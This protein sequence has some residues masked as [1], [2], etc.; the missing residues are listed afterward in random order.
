VGVVDAFDKRR[1]AFFWTGEEFCSG[2]HCKVAW[3]DVGSPKNLGGLGI[4]S[5]PSQNSA[6]LSKFLSKLHSDSSALWAC[7]LRRS[8]GWASGH[9]LGEPHHFDTPV[10][11]GIRA[12]LP[13][14][15]SISIVTLGN[16]ASA[17]FWFDS[18]TRPHA[19]VASVFQNGPSVSLAPRFSSPAA[20]QLTMLD[21]SLA[22]TTLRPDVPDTRLCRATNKSLSNKDFYSFTF[23]HCT[24]D[25]G[26]CCS[27]AMQ[28]LRL[29]RP[30]T[31]TLNQCKAFSSS[32]RVHCYLSLL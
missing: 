24:E 15:H 31:S 19:D 27:I 22:T 18:C 29:A 8:Y 9:D 6:F 16:G 21:A 20:S 1:R 3:S 25:L 11:K 4:L 17:S 5:I 10:W 30:S 7:W 13:T 26:K 14:F 28:D 2:G 32:T 23:R 12:G